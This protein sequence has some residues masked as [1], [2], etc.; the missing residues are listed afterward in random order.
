MSFSRSKITGGVYYKNIRLVPA[1]FYKSKNPI[2]MII[3]NI[4]A[5]MP[6]LSVFN[7]SAHWTLAGQLARKAFSFAL[8]CLLACA[9]ALALR[10]ND[11][12]NAITA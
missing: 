8:A 2:A 1:V 10:T 4:V 9:L 3:Q 12:V 5:S 7:N 6:Y 11:A